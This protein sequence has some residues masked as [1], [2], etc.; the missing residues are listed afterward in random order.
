MF[1]PL[2]LTRQEIDQ[3][4]VQMEKKGVKF[5]KG[6]SDSEFVAIEK[7]YYNGKRFPPDLRAFLE[8]AL[9]ISQDAS[10][11]SED[12][13]NWRDPE[14]MREYMERYGHNKITDEIIFDIDENDVW[15]HSWGEKPSHPGHRFDPLLGRAVTYKEMMAAHWQRPITYGEKVMLHNYWA[16]LKEGKKTLEEGKAQ[17]REL[18]HNAPR[19][20]PI[21]GRRFMATEPHTCG[22][23]V[24]SIFLGTDIIFYGHDLAHFLAEE[25]EFPPIR[26]TPTGHQVVIPFWHEVAEYNERAN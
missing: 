12:F 19:L 1:S 20:V 3:L 5:D 9:P 25:F 23:P 15:C 16:T 7:Q 17:V 11:E 2:E 26:P 14:A 8:V 22:Q 6:L 18:I 4:V 24:L 13:P 10:E 21:C